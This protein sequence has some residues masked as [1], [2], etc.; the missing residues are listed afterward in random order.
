MS[1]EVALL[2]GK[3]DVDRGEGSASAEVE[4]IPCDSGDTTVLLVESAEP[5][6]ITLVMNIFGRC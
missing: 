1:L 2:Y 5:Y 4:L 3:G 6:Y